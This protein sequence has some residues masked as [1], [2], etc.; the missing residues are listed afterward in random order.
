MVAP[1]VR[2]PEPELDL[3][4]LELDPDL[5]E[6]PELDPDLL[7]PRELDPDLLVLRELD[8]LPPEEALAGVGFFARGLLKTSSNFEYSR[9]LS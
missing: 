4:R 1:R 6:P 9:P 5:L 3:V 7:L 2:L 8:R